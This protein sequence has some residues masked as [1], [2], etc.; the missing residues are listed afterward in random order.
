M[1]DPKDDPT[2][3]FIAECLDRLKKKRLTRS[4]V[5][6]SE[7]LRARRATEKHRDPPPESLPQSSPL[8]EKQQDLLDRAVEASSKIDRTSHVTRS[9]IEQV[10]EANALWNAY[11]ASLTPSTDF[12]G[13][14][15]MA[16]FEELKWQ[17]KKP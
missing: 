8:S 5:P 11:A 12:S 15:W 1:D 6:P 13:G 4:R 2:F 16:T 17:A 7:I 10:K 9:T 3:P 14:E